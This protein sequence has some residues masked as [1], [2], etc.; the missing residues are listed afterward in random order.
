MSESEA[1]GI[2]LFRTDASMMK[3]EVSAEELKYR[4]TEY[5]STLSETNYYDHR[6]FKCV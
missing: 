2:T 1:K 5:S 4:E 3:M 6:A